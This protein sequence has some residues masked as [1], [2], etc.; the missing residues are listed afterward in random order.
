MCNIHDA[1]VDAALSMSDDDN[2]GG[3]GNVGI[4]YFANC[5]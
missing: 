4:P 5:A 3:T 2:G 1:T